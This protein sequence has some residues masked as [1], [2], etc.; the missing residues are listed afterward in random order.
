MLFQV[1]ES[2]GHHDPR[3]MTGRMRGGVG[4]KVTNFAAIGFKKAGMA[5][6]VKSRN[7]LPTVER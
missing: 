5:D 1:L 2:A 6:S 7:H 4:H 3:H